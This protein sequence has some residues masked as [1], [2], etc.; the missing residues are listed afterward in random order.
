MTVSTRLNAPNYKIFEP[1]ALDS[2]YAKGNLDPIMGGISYAF[3]SANK[4]NAEV[5]QANYLASQDKFN[6]MAANLDAAEIAQKQREAAMKIAG[7]LIGHGEGPDKLQGGSD[8]YNNVNDA[9][10]PGLLRNKLS[11]EAN[12][13]N[14]K[15]SADRNG[16]ALT[17]TRTYEVDGVTYTV[18]DKSKGGSVAV[19]PP[20]PPPKSGV[21]SPNTDNKTTVRIL[22]S[23]AVNHANPKIDPAP[24]GK[25]QFTNPETGK[26]A[27]LD[28][29][30]GK[31]DR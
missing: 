28:R 9:L 26:T 30:T 2:I 11:A 12:A 14:S 15:A 5:N 10:L 1:D 21:T 29:V 13:A 27:V 3:G 16:P 8:I 4:Q 7:A 31:Q 17:N 18:Q 19:P 22:G 23:A 20:P 24:N 25:V 6:K